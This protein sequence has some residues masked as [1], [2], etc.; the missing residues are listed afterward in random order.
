MGQ[1]QCLGNSY[2]E[3]KM[4]EHGFY[5]SSK[6]RVARKESSATTAYSI[7]TLY[8]MAESQY[9]IFCLKTREK[10]TF[11]PSQLV[12]SSSLPCGCPKRIDLSLQKFF[13][14]INEIESF[15]LNCE[16]HEEEIVCYC[17]ECELMLCRKCIDK[18]HD[19]FFGN[20][21]LYYKHKKVL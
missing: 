9:E 4:L 14:A 5:I 2:P 10:F 11:S 19:D 8:E 1:C 21:H 18:F 7:S 6:K 17:F 20:H 16:R 12:K 3:E 15:D 13:N